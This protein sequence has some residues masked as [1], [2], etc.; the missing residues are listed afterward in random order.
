MI[1]F[2]EFTWFTARCWFGEWLCERTASV[3]W[4]VCYYFYLETPFL[5]EDGWY[6][7]SRLLRSEMYRTLPVII[8]PHHH[9]LVDSYQSRDLLYSL[10]I[11][12][13]VFGVGFF[14]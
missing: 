4:L 2:G 14:A 12:Q 9:L 6:V 13:D 7:A 1:F 3:E 8:V 5:P 11:V 10:Q